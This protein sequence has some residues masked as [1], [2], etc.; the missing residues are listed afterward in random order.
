MMLYWGTSYLD[1][2]NHEINQ[3]K[4]T[5]VKPVTLLRIKLSR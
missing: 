3:S 4:K 1:N 5:V 2:I